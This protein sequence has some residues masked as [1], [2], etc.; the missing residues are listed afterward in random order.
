MSHPALKWLLIMGITG[1]STSM[2]MFL[3]EFI[4]ITAEASAYYDIQESKLLYFYNSFNVCTLLFS[5]ILF[6]IFKKY[7]F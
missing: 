7:Y 5:P 2:L 4:A 1:V 6:G 3:S